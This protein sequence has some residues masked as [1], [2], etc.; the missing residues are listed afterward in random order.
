MSYSDGVGMLP[1]KFHIVQPGLPER[2]CGIFL[3]ALAYLPV[4]FFVLTQNVKKSQG[5]TN[6]P[7]F[8]R[9]THK[10]SDNSWPFIYP[11]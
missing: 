2:C 11:D 9:P 1:A 7:L 8:V 5:Q 4:Y 10:D 6:V 3:M